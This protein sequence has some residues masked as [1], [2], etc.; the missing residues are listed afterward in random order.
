MKYN[1]TSYQ[2]FKP[3]YDSRYQIIPEEKGL[4]GIMGSGGTQKVWVI[5]KQIRMMLK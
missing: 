1:I 4:K 3:S 5:G 2:S